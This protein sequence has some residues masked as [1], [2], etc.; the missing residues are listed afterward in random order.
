MYL[1]P[2]GQGHKKGKKPF[3]TSENALKSVEIP[4]LKQTIKLNEKLKR[5]TQKGNFNEGK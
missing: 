5:K 4:R 3:R 1:K 2:R